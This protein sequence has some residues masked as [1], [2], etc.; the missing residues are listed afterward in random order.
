MC[1]W[2]IVQGGQRGGWPTPDYQVPTE[3][4]LPLILLEIHGWNYHQGVRRVVASQRPPLVGRS[5]CSPRRL[6][7]A[8][9]TRHEAAVPVGGD[10]RRTCRIR[11]R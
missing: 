1:S 11:S 8:A 9:T 6:L 4:E 3:C 2:Q 5:R 7:H 10:S